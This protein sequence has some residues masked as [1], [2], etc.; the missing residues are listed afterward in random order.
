MV[1]MLNY[2]KRM[3]REIR[4]SLTRKVVLGYFLLVLLPSMLLGIQYYT[5]TRDQLM[6]QH[7]YNLQQTLGQS[8][9][10][11]DNSLATVSGIFNQLQKYNAFLRFLDGEIEK[12]VNQLVMYISEFSSM[13]TYLLGQSNDIAA[14]KIYVADANILKMGQYLFSADDLPDYR[15]D[16]STLNGY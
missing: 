9:I 16:T 5:H 13:L 11:A 4:D 3:V 15:F 6:Q 1:R 12:P 10:N 7:N 14:V 8:C 2:P